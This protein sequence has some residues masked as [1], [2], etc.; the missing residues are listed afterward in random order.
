M[1]C[2]RCD[3]QG[4]VYIVRINAT[5]EVVRLCDECEAMAAWR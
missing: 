4:S 2:P 1:Q 3:N 5:G